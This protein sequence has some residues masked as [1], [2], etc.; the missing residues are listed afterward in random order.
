MYYVL[1]IS[2]FHALGWELLPSNPTAQIMG[3]SLVGPMIYNDVSYYVMFGGR[4]V[5]NSLTNTVHVFEPGEFWC[6]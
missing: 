2:D 1:F 4:K 5:D 3:F 6:M